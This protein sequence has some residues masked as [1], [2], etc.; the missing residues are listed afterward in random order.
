MSDSSEG[1]RGLP[2]Q[3]GPL[4]YHL[5]FGIWPNIESGDLLRCSDNLEALRE[6]IIALRA[7]GQAWKEYAMIIERKVAQ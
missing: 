6:E 5:D 7:W 4:C 3:P 1:K 2:R